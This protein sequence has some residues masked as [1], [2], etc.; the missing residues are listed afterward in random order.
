MDASWLGVWKQGVRRTLAHFRAVPFTLTVLAAFLAI[1]ALTGSFL[2]GAPHALLP[3]VSVSAPGLKAGHWWSLFTSLFFASNLLA[4]LAASLMILLLLGLAERHLGT[5]RTAVFFFV[6]QFAAVT[7]FLLITQLARYLGDG[8]LGLMVSARLI[9]PYAA[10]LAVVLAASGLLPTLWQRRLRTAVV[11]VSLLLVLY[12]GH[13]ETVVGL[14]GAL[15]GL[16][17]GWWIQGDR[18]TL[19]RHRSTGRETRNLLALTVTIFAVGPILTAV[20]SSPT[21]PLALLR[22]VVLNP[23][24][25]LSQLEE[26]CGGTVDVNC[27]EA[28][29]AG[30][31]GPLGLALAVVPVVLLLICADGMRQGR[32]LALRIAIIVQLGVTALAAVYLAL[33]ARIPHYPNGPRPA[34]MGS[35]FVHVL[36]LVAVPLLVVVLLWFN[37]RQFRVETAP[38][39]RRTLGLV[40][41]GTWLAL[42]GAYTGAWLAA[43]G[44]DRDGGPLGLVAELAR[45]YL[46]LPI[47]GAYSRLFQN[48]NA[49][50]AFLF[51]YAG[52]IFWGVALAAVWLVLRRRLHGTGMTGTDVG[53]G[54][55]DTAREL[56]R[57]GGDS[58]SWMALWEPNKYWFT[59]DRRGGIAYQQH[60]NIA[61]TLAGPFGPAALHQETAAGFMR[62]CAENALIP[63]FYSCTDGL[64][65]ML[66]ARGFRRVA[67]AQ[68][69]RLAVRELEFKGKQWQNVRTALN[70]AAKTGVRAVWGRYSGFPAPLRAQLSEVSEEWA[71]QKHV[72]EMGFTLGSMDELDDDDVLCCL[73]VDS[74]GRVHGVTS[75]LPVFEDGRIVSWTLDFMRRRG[76]AF[77][78]VMEFLIA[79]AVRELKRTVEVISLSGSPLAKDRSG[80]D[81]REREGD[82]G[83]GALGGGRGGGNAGDGDGAPGAG[84]QGDAGPEGLAGIL[85]VVGRALEPIY[86]FRS[87]AT[88]K[89]RFK[90]DYRTLYLY[91]QDPLQLPA[92]G[93]ALSRAY[94]PG[95]SVRQSARLLRTLVR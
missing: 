55:R 73:A 95:L 34:V 88:F 36:P 86:G 30:F 52:I 79:S 27:L 17:A 75:W 46:P 6:G 45:Q 47:P 61:L 80:D 1:G 78:G 8:W 25:T 48:R 64:W 66:S 43:G 11:S 42:T 87:L 65:P 76:D 26:N 74:A 12:V 51:A 77:P 21:G 85:D 81:A 24:P 63:C 20:V 14:C 71:A 59:P 58:L 18:G 40:V 94:L 3:I 62:Y 91:Y 70:R 23:L 53:S 28:G 41:G 92:M 57:Q 33:F 49:V 82:D 54:D 69:T 68:E 22:D 7:L 44:M 19:H 37:R 4:Y 60:G 10:V 13:A 9:G 35:G 50:E 38:L 39:A 56:I 32:R 15:A 93:R 84:G 2:S 29:R 16:A 89:S 67:V 90:P 31:A 83:G 72:P 5:L